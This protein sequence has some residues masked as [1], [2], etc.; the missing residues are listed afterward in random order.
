MIEGHG[1]KSVTA[2]LF[3]LFRR[4]GNSMTM[5]FYEFLKNQMFGTTRRRNCSNVDFPPR[6]FCSRCYAED[7]EW[8][9]VPKEEKVIA[10]TRQKRALRFTDPETI[11]VLEIG[12]FPRVITKIE[13]EDLRIGD[14]AFLVFIEV[15]WN[16][17]PQI[18]Q[19]EVLI[20]V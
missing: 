19:K 15:A 4:Y 13:G 10:F 7:M 16:N 6:M 5:L 12:Y 1:R 20:H 2:K 9:E 14:R 11:G 18:Y 8:V 17:H 3:E